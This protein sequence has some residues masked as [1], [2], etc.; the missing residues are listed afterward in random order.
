[1]NLSGD[2][3][4]SRTMDKREDK[5]GRGKLDRYMFNMLILMLF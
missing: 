3:G 1:M 4:A 5:V 2:V